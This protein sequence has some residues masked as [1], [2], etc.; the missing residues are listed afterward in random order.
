MRSGKSNSPG[1]D[2]YWKGGQPKIVGNV[3]VDDI[4]IYTRMS[5]VLRINGLFHPYISRLDTSHE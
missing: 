5:M 1:G 2:Y 3:F 4:Y